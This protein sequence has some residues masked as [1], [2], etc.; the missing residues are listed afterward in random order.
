MPESTI[1]L[2]NQLWIGLQ[3]MN[4]SNPKLLA[5]LA[6]LLFL[7]D[8]GYEGQRSPSQP[9]QLIIFSIISIGVFFVVYFAL[10][11]PARRISNP[12][13]RGL[14]QILL[15]V[16]AEMAKSAALIGLLHPDQFVSRYLERLPG[17]ITIA[18]L[19]WLIAGVASTAFEE[20]RF[21]I[22]EL[23]R[24]S[25]KLDEKRQIRIAAATGVEEELQEKASQ[26]LIV[27]LDKLSK[28]SESVL[29]S[30]EMSRLKLQIQSLIRNQVRPLSREL[31]SRVEV[32]QSKEPVKAVVARFSQIPRMTCIPTLDTSLVA[33]YFISIPN[34]FLTVL[35]KTSLINS[36]LILAISISY[37]IIGRFLQIFLPRKRVS[38]FQGLFLA[39]VLSLISYLP[40][41]FM[42]SMFT[43][44]SPLLGITVVSAGGVLV[45]TAIFGSSWF[46]LQRERAER[47][48]EVEQLNRKTKHEM[49]L[50]DQ[51]M[52]VAQR[53]WSYLIHGSVQAALTVAAAR[54]EMSSR[55]DERLRVAVRSDIE[56]AKRTLLEPPELRA[57]VKGLLDEV[58]ATWRG[59]C[60]FDYQISPSV[61]E[62]LSRSSTATTCFVEIIKELISNANRH[63]SATKF[64]LNAYLNKDGDL[65]IVAG[66]NGK[67]MGG[68]VSSGLGLQM[69]SVLTKRWIFERD[70]ATGFFAVLP[71]PRT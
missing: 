16:V 38:P 54:L 62:A 42:I 20:H 18:A 51:A 11:F 5:M 2:L 37:P 7:T 34:I 1:Q 3:K 21:A 66:N 24:A 23:N 56:R 17:D 26:A 43:Q 49:D 57:E 36:L 69:I 32:L 13:A 28:L 67:P 30:A 52:W 27:E 31:R 55:P 19:Y 65:D 15:V 48:E 58:A 64:W 14:A 61:V 68:A 45:F 25:E 6:I 39:G 63:G 71:L 10:V 4:P 9:I 70:K 47:V 60:E 8:I 50:L 53:K 29:D 41:G 46:L 40:T 44:E 12:S 59:V 22:F 35:S 33:S